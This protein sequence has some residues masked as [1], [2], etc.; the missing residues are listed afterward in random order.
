MFRLPDQESRHCR[1]DQT[2][3][4][5]VQRSETHQ[6]G[7]GTKAMGIAMLTHPTLAASYFGCRTR[8]A[9]MAGI[10]RMGAA[11]RNPS[12]RVRYESDGYRYAHPSYACYTP[13]RG[14]SHGGN[15]TPG[16]EW[17]NPR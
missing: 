11:K 12:A 15:F 6:P 14:E 8:K 7:C 16:A 17:F 13:S 4:G 5:W 1:N 3:V 2:F 9:A 10:R